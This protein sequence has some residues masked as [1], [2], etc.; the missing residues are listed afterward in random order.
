MKRVAW[1][2]GIPHSTGKGFL[3]GKHSPE[4]IEKLR[5]A[6]KRRIP[7]IRTLETRAKMRAAKILGEDRPCPIC[8]ESVYWARWEMKRQKHKTC[9]KKC[10]SVLFNRTRTGRK[11]TPEQRLVISKRMLGNTHTLD[12]RFSDEEKRRRSIIAPRG[13]A[14]WSWKGGVTAISMQIRKSTEYGIWRAHV[15]QRDNWTCVWCGA[16]SK[17][18]SFI[19]INADHIKPFAQYPELRFDVS[20]GRTLCLPCHKNTPSYGKNVQVEKAGKVI[21]RESVRV[22]VQ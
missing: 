20:N 10:L 3:G 12:H 19:M 14:R 9:S 13:P 15:F 1:N 2:K 11:L 17:K 18:G 21:R 6:A 4:A 8:G 22:E 7:Y 5:A 16:K